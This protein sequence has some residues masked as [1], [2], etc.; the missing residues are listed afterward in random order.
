MKNSK[1][2]KITKTE[3]ENRRNRRDQKKRTTFRVLYEC[4]PEPFEP[5]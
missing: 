2:K 5:L 1:I 3:G 4:F